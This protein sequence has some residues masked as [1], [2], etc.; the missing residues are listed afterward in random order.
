ML[1]RAMRRRLLLR[2]TKARVGAFTHT[3]EFPHSSDRRGTQ[4]VHLCAVE[5]TALARVTSL[6][7]QILDSR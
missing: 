6:R 3:F 2:S 1:R 5:V 7:Q 4:R